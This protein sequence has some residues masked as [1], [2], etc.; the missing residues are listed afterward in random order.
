M[1]VAATCLKERQC[2]P[3]DLLL[4]LCVRQLFGSYCNAHSNDAI[5]AILQTR[6]AKRNG[7]V[8]TAVWFVCGFWLNH[9]RL[10]IPSLIKVIDVQRSAAIIRHHRRDT[11]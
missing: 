1:A 8:L 6:A 11:Q 4:H 9:H 7:I 3:C 5:T 2:P 10:H